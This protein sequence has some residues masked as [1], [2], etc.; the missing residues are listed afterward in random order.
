ME[1]GITWFFLK[2]SLG[3]PAPPRKIIR[4]KGLPSVETDVDR[5][6]K[7]IVGGDSSRNAGLVETLPIHGLER[8]QLSAAQRKC[9]EVKAAH[10]GKAAELEG[11]EAVRKVLQELLVGDR[12]A[13][14][15]H[16]LD[17]VIRSLDKFEMVGELLFRRVDN[18]VSN[19]VELRCVTPTGNVRVSDFRGRG[20]ICLGFPEGDPASLSQW[21]ARRPPRS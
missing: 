5:L 10:A 13:L 12:Q 3:A 4:S 8:A 15:G 2:E 11:P 1:R 18:P 20:R 9:P 17:A 7:K 16:E 6:L 21:A 14:N 19:H